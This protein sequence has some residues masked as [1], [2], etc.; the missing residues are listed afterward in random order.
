MSPGRP[1]EA[2]GCFRL[3]FWEVQDA[4]RGARALCWLCTP[5]DAS[6][7]ALVPLLALRRV[8]ARGSVLGPDVLRLAETIP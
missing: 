7:R 2:A 6:G 3:A 4:P 8:Y 5:E 1:C